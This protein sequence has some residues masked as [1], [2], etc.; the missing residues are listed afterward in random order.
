MDYK[1]S[2]IYKITDIGY[3]KMYIGST[4]QPL[5]KRLSKHKNDY[6]LWKKNGKVHKIMSYDLFD[7]F[8]ID[9]CKIELILEYACENRDQLHKK[10]GEYIKNNICVNKLIAGRTIKEYQQE[11]YQ[12]N[13]QTILEQKKEYRQNN[14]Q[15]I[16]EQKK[17]WY[18]NNKQTIAEQK[19]EW[20]QNNK[21][22]ILEQKKE[23]RQKN[24][25][26]ILEQ[27]KKYRQ[28]KREEILEKLKE[29]Q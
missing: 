7:E 4:T 17:E 24:K 11:Y 26:K 15:T 13:K 22:K 10:E 5:Y 16:A 9:N 6:K 8:G 29:N 3:N 18:Q 14:K 20:Y 23:Y 27:K 2:K 21:Q 19:K 1:N 12:N 28:K 25:Q